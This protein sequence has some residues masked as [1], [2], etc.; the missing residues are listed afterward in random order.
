MQTTRWGVTIP[1]I[2][3]AKF[4]ASVS[5]CE[6]ASRG[7]WYPPFWPEKPRAHL[8]GCDCQVYS[9]GNQDSYTMKLKKVSSFQE[10]PQLPFVCMFCEN[11]CEFLSSCTRAYAWRGQNKTTV[12]FL[13]HPP[14]WLET[15]PLT[16]L[17]ALF[18]LAGQSVSSQD[19]LVSTPQYRHIFYRL[20]M[21]ML[22]ILAQVLR[23]LSL[24]SKWP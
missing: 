16:E 13:H 23:S 3:C 2:Q 5:L 18:W 24:Y 9:P 8:H 12:D 21:W 11:A 19:P 22:G 6:V 7:G 14:N 10:E 17:G 1:K 4:A 15:E 20:F